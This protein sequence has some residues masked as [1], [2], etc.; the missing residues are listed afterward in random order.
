M[1]VHCRLP[2]HI[3]SGRPGTLAS[4]ILKY[5]KL[6]RFPNIFLT[7]EHNTVT[8]SQRPK[9]G[10]FPF[11]RK[12]R[13]GSE[14]K[15]HFPESHFGILG[16]PREVVQIFRNIGITGKFCSIRPFLLGPVSPRG[17]NTSL[18]LS[19]SNVPKAKTC[20]V[21][22]IAARPDPLPSGIL[23]DGMALRINSLQ[24]SFAIRK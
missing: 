7:Q 14:W 23:P 17:L 2:L 21:A 5:P 24:V 9:L 19:S 10:R 22:E 4:S 3:S 8:P 1:L 13:L 15:G 18:P 20:F 6:E 11:D 16:V 12:F